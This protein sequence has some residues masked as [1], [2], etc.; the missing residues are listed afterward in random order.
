MKAKRH[1]TAKDT[2]K[3]VVVEI[4]RLERLETTGSLD[5]TNGSRAW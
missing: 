4:R 5:G 3:K 1:E 2:N